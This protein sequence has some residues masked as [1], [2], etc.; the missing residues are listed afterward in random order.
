MKAWRQEGSGD[1]A[2][3][4]AWPQEGSEDVAARLAREG[5]GQLYGRAGGAV[6]V[7]SCAPL[8]LD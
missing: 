2:G 1:V 7:C 4:K 5:L 3:V 6:Y 8:L